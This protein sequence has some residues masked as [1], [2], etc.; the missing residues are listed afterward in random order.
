MKQ[1][2]LVSDSLWGGILNFIW[3][4]IPVLWR[5]LAITVRGPGNQEEVTAALVYIAA[6]LPVTQ[7]SL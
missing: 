1:K 6:H 3:D 2:T 7:A 5:G 4:M